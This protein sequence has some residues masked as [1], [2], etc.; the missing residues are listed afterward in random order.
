M[1]FSGGPAFVKLVGFPL[2]HPSPRLEDHPAMDEH[3]PSEA[4]RDAFRDARR[5]LLTGPVDPDGDSIGACLALARGLREICA[6]RVDVAGTPSFRYAWMPGADAMVPDERV[7]GPYDVAVVL[8]GDR[9]RLTAPVHRAY[10]SARL[11]ILIDHHASTDPASYDIALLDPHA[12]SATE[13]VWQVLERWGITLDRELA[14]LLY[15]G[16][17]FDTGGFRYSNTSPSCHTL[18]A[19]LLETGVEHAPIAARVLMERR[20]GGV[21]LLGHVLST[22]SLSED[23]QVIVGAISQEQLRS[24]DASEADIEGIVDMLVFTRGVEIA[25]LAIERAPGRV[26]LSLRSRSRVDVAALARQLTS[27]GGGH[28]RAAGAS[29][30]QALEEVLGWL[31]SALEQ[32][33]IAEMR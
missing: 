5:V 11:K 15:T 9:R 25:C 14:A 18:A 16:L 3:L 32:A 30:L 29:L 4:L 2:P 6:A 28:P 17:I 8:D 19:K 24:F 12:S 13:L 20:S 27:G 31:P 21:R 7:E 26:K 1:R 23:G 33:A 22:A 10:E